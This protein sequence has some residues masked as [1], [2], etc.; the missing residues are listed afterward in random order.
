MDK[1]S[2]EDK[3]I[4][5]KD[6]GGDEDEAAAPA[7]HTLVGLH[8]FFNGPTRSR[9]CKYHRDCVRVGDNEEPV[10]TPVNTRK[11]PG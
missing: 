4:G 6:H 3:D 5:S 11:A 2:E 10:L 7:V 9:R 1:G 8:P